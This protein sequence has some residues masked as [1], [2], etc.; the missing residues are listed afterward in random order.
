MPSLRRV[1][2]FAGVVL[3]LFFAPLAAEFGLVTLQGH[4]ATYARLLAVLVSESFAYG[5]A[6]GF[7][8][9]MPHWTSMAAWLQIT[10][11]VHAALGSVVLL[12]C[13][14]QLHTGFR[15][16]H[17]SVHRRL[18][19]V[20]AT[21]GVVTM[22]LAIAYLVATPMDAIFGGPPFALGLW[23]MAVMALW[24]LGMGV[25]QARRGNMD[26]HQAFM[27]LFAATLFVAPSLRL[28]WVLF[29][30][31]LGEGAHSTQATAHIL[32]LVI[33]SVQTPLLAIGAMARH[34]RQRPTGDVGSPML[35]AL[36]VLAA[37]GLAWSGMPAF[38]S[39]LGLPAAGGLLAVAALLLA[40]ATLPGLLGERGPGPMVV[41][42]GVLACAGWGLAA[43]STWPTAGLAAAHLALGQGAYLVVMSL[44]VATLTGLTVGAIR[45]RDDGLAH[46]TGLHILAFTAVP[47]VHQ[48]LVHVG[49]NAGL[50]LAD[51]WLGA[52]VL[53]PGVLLSFSFY[54]TAFRAR[55][56]LGRQ[57]LGRGDV[58]GSALTIRGAVSD[59]PGAVALR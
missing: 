4:T 29:G 53:A 26:A 5:P 52:A 8:Q 56:S 10:L 7:A 9:L 27:L 39:P 16:R 38:F 23:G 19:R 35:L 43:W 48:A 13:L 30:W 18:G 54:A 45:W 37:V 31:L 33:L 32:A 22:V 3:C 15:R 47:A 46:E 24:S 40:V 36:P 21:L 55:S 59:A 6:S 50:G 28:Y 51:T 14:V 44:S 12:L 1:L 2:I 11:G 42:G 17:P 57:R 20:T 41:L 58:E 34:R 25:D 49:S